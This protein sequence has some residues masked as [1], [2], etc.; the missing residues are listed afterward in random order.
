MVTEKDKFGL[1]GCF[2]LIH[3]SMGLGSC[4]LAVLSVTIL[5]NVTS[6]WAVVVVVYYFATSGNPWVTSGAPLRK[7]SWQYS[8]SYGILRG[9]TRFGLVQG[10]C[11]TGCA[12]S[13]SGSGDVSII[14]L[15]SLIWGL[16][17]TPFYC[18]ATCLPTRPTTP[19]LIMNFR[20]FCL[21]QLHC[22]SKSQKPNVFI[23]V[24]L[25]FT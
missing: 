18:K 19:Q 24:S 21:Q 23:V 5:I 14:I 1:T 7:H 2:Q 11:P 17:K 8:G 3:S 6:L 9:S 16:L 10:K 13:L 25:N 12:H 4:W 15:C 20:Y 22:Y